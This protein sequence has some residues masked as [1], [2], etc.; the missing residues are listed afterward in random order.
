MILKQNISFFIRD[1]KQR[2]ETAFHKFKYLCIC[3]KLNVNAL[4]EF[5]HTYYD[6]IERDDS[7]RNTWGRVW[8]RKIF[9]T[10]NETVKSDLLSVNLKFSSTNENSTVGENIESVKDLYMTGVWIKF[11][12]S[13]LIYIW[14]RER[15]REVGGRWMFFTPIF[16]LILTKTILEWVPVDK[17]LSKEA[18]PKQYIYIYIY[19][20]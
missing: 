11:D 15:E 9:I 6:F 18:T 16:V 10:L 4:M 19:T 14:E 1:N 2:L 17:L 7:H 12:K 5:E 8:N 13:F 3:S 20:S